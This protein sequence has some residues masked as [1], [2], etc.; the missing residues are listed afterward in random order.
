MALS[1]ELI[2]EFVKVTNDKTEVKQESTVYGTIVEYEGSK[3]V[4]LDGSDLLTPIPDTTTDV[5][6]DER[7]TV[8]IKNHAVTITGNLSSPAAR[9]ESVQQ[10]GNQIT[11]VEILVADKVSTKEFDAQ[12]GRI[13]NLISDNVLIR[14]ELAANKA[15]IDDL[16]ADN[17]TINEKLTAQ[18]AEIVELETSKL[19][20]K[21]ADIKY[22]TIENLNATNAQIHTLEGDYGE[23]RVLTADRLSAVDA[24]IKNLHADKLD[25]DEADIRYA[26]I[27]ELNAEKAKI[28]DLT[29]DVAD[30]DTLIFGSASGSTIQTSFANAVIAQL[31]NAQIKSAMIDSVTAS[32]IVSGDI[33]TDKVNVK[34]EDG[35]LI[36]SDETIQ[37]SDD[38]RVRVQIG[39]D[40]SN[41]YSI[42]VWDAD[43]NLMFSEGGITDSAIKEAIIRN[44]MVSND[45][46]I[47]ASKL[48]IDSL[49]TEING[50]T[51]TI[52]ST[53]IYLDDKKQ[54]LDVAFNS[55]ST[56]VDGI[57]DD[58]KT[59]ATAISVIQGQISS[60]VWQ[61][62]INTAIDDV[63]GDIETLSTKY[64]TLDQDLDSISATVASHTTQISNKAD[65]STVTS[66]SNKV[67]SLETDLDG[68]RTSV[69]STYATKTEVNNA[70]D[71]LEEITEDLST[72][73]STLQQ[74]VN[75]LSSTVT[76]HTS[77]IANKADK[78]TVTTVTNQVAELESGL[79][80]FKS[81]VSSTYATK[82]ALKTTDDKAVA[83]QNGV[84]TLTS[85]TNSLESS[86]TQN[87]N[88][89]AL[90]VSKEEMAETL[91]GEKYYGPR[92]ILGQ[93]AQDDCIEGQGIRIVSDLKPIQ[94]GDGKPYTVGGGTNMLVPTYT[95][96]SINSATITYDG[97]AYFTMNGTPTQA[98]VATIQLLTLEAG[99]YTMSHVIVGGSH[100]S[101]SRIRVAQFV[102]DDTNTVLATT[103][104]D[105][106][107]TTYTLTETTNIRVRI[108]G[109]VNVTYTD[110]KFGVQLE[111]GSTAT[112]YKPYV[113]ICPISGRTSA[114]AGSSGKNLFDYRD[115]SDKTAYV[116]C[117]L[118]GE[119]LRIYT[120][121][122]NDWQGVR[123]RQSR[124]IAK[125]GV[126]YRGSIKVDTYTSGRLTFGLRAYSTGT[127]QSS[128]SATAAGS[129]YT[130]SY[131]PTA[132]I[133]VYASILVSSSSVL[134][135]DITISN[136]Q[137]E[138]DEVTDYE[139]FQGDRF[140]IDF[141][142][143][144][145][146]GT[147]VWNTGVVTVNRALY[148]FDGTES[149]SKLV[150]TYSQK[151]SVFGFGKLTDSCAGYGTS[152]CSHFMNRNTGHVASSAVDGVVGM[153]SDHRT[154]APESSQHNKYFRWGNADTTAAEFKA[155]IAEQYAAGTPVQICYTLKEPYEIQLT[156]QQ[157]VAVA[158]LNTVHTNLPDGRIEFGHDSLVNLGSASNY[159]LTLV[160]ENMAS[161]RVD[162]DNIAASVS[163]VE[164]S[165]LDLSESVANDVQSIIKQVETKMTADA[166]DI[167]IKSALDNGVDRVITSTG[168]TLDE[169][170]LTVSKSD[171]EMSTTITDDGMTV[172]KNGE[173]TLSANSTGVD[174]VNL[175]A[176][177]YLIIGNNSRFED[178][179]TR[180]ACFWI[181]D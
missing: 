96:N 83:A 135:G 4:R 151:S 106:P 115:T 17:V 1:S 39:K 180:T 55:M 75:G 165:I 132:D 45:A 52:N 162:T 140:A 120:T 104:T 181:G 80:G 91:G 131:T 158:G 134:S 42:N 31:G 171:S 44:D 119:N 172:Y 105:T 82:T 21:D 144:V 84:N 108:Y 101:S 145:Y 11:E 161:L 53:K 71:E 12:N 99:T 153:Y 59:N 114:Y 63:E 38:N 97:S 40:A 136:C 112:T 100:S 93:F 154:T 124:F 88:A 68:F 133:E 15:T 48:D 127:F 121:S 118:N 168:Y 90:K 141:G 64:T 87:S 23:F 167:Q 41:D 116:E 177:T 49:F 111:K 3:Y 7:V 137:I 126:R 16:T 46:N 10:I 109:T 179:G 56:D 156:P 72:K 8:M 29:A 36:I 85:K 150:D 22:A 174:A 173:T 95:N 81:T 117:E 178:W 149:F 142:Q 159:D 98:G 163:S 123:Y 92:I 19:T 73:H 67:T 138:I 33:I 47:S 35:R 74:T 86:I 107:S 27:T 30:I 20:A 164:T 32:K 139:E 170:G 51:K 79:N 5:E 102:A 78:S 152:I 13:D 9:T 14:Q 28:V 57:S 166:V 25:A 6:P 110:W 70:T 147:I 155:F 94:E 65:K 143:T 128:V 148:T 103:W 66:V 176:T 54:T 77:Q 69:S 169:D 125:K 122:D 76:S 26:T 61:Q 2:S 50:S 37:I 113:N 160:Q 43:G 129:N 62:D 157:I 146:G 18:E 130:F 89:I 58:V 34:S 175:H 24:D 60:K